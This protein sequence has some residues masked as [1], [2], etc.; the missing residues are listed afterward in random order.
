MHFD[1]MCSIEKTGASNADDIYWCDVNVHA[2][3]GCNPNVVLLVNL[4]RN[5]T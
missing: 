4:A 3:V 2:F 5:Q 1:D